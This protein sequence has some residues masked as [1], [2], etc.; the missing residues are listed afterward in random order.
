MSEETK[1]TS[2]KQAQAQFDQTESTQVDKIKS[3]SKNKNR[4]VL[5]R[6]LRLEKGGMWRDTEGEYA[7]GKVV[8]AL[9][10]IMVGRNTKDK[11]S[12]IPLDK[13]NNQN[14]K[15]YGF[16]EQT[17]L[18]WY[19][20][21]SSVPKENLGRIIIAYNAG[22]LVRADPE[23]PPVFKKPEVSSD[24]KLKKDGAL[25]FNGKNTEMYKKLQNLNF[26]KLK[27]FVNE[28]PIS[29]TSFDNLRDLLDYERRGFNPL[30]RPRL[31]VLDL[32][33]A[34]LKEFGPGITGI[35]KNEED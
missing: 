2:K 33:R 23:N 19:I 5:P 21:L 29:N 28:S 6:Y 35:R 7:S 11:D 24:W 20:D 14:F 17:D 16:I 12:D 34:K 30:S 22:I 27:D 31:E 18:P 10:N 15:E 1:T 3:T 4:L 26:K 8:Y 9:K 25:V 32:I 13:Y